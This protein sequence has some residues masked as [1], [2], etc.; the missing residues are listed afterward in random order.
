MYAA[1]ILF[2]LIAGTLSLF[3]ILVHY[4]ASYCLLLPAPLQVNKGQPKEYNL[5]CDYLVVVSL[6]NKLTKLQTF[7]VY[8]KVK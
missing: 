5:Y 2:L 4:V 1:R 8:K 3:S 6:S 7:L